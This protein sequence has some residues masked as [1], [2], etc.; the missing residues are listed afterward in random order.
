MSSLDIK[1]LR[2]NVA[3]QEILRGLNLSVEKG[4]VHAIMGPNGSGKSTLS[5]VIAGH[6]DY[7]VTAGSIE[8]DIN[9]RKKNLLE[10]AP[11]ERARNGIF[12][13]FQYPIEV[14]GVPNS[15]FL[16]AAF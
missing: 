8:Y 12:L 16:R 1:D 10:M 4:K 11:E 7:E 9:F 2:A 15:A 5:K 3:G 6:P 13:A 14:P